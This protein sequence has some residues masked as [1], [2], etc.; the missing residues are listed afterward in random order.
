MTIHTA[1]KARYKQQ[2]AKEQVDQG[3]LSKSAPDDG[4]EV[5]F[6]RLQHHRNNAYH[7]QSLLKQWRE[8]FNESDEDAEYKFGAG[9]K[10]NDE[11]AVD[12]VKSIAAMAFFTIQV[13][14]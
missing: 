10:E 6:G 13:F 14:V 12:N 8:V 4:E 2:I 1:L 5:F 11:S 3:K 9:F 7:H